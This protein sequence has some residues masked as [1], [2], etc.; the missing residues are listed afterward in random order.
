MT[1]KNTGNFRERRELS[2]KGRLRLT[3][4]NRLAAT[5]GP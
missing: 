3:M 5:I 4:F 1:R 2:V